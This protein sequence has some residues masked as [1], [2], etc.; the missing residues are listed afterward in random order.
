ME[1]LPW[2]IAT[3]F[4]IT[5]LLAIG[6]FSKAA[7]YAK[8]FIT[9][10]FVLI[11][12][13]SALGLA[14]FYSNP[15]TLTTR[16]PLLVAPLLFFCIAQFFTQKGK[17][18]LDSLDIKALTILHTIRVGVETVLFW[19]FVH[20]AI[21]RAMSFEG[22]NLDIL[23]GLTAP[24]VY[25]FGFV[26]HKLSRQVMIVWNVA[27]ML[28]LFNVVTNAFLSLPARFENFGFE[29]PLIAVGYFP[30]LLL[31]AILVPLILFSN[32]ATIRQLVLN[33]NPSIKN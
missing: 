26:K 22:R 20:K 28:L 3:T 13:Q 21:P 18:F 1:Q 16:F 12:I 19:L 15:A 7:H 17:L 5:F 30:F 25:Y 29:Q 27:C 23:S 11:V 6:L 14:G 10:L 9:V 8:S 24:L 2:Y 33:K 31:P 32:G 4:G